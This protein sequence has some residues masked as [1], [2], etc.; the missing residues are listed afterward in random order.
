MRSFTRL[1]PRAISANRKWLVSGMTKSKSDFFRP[2]KQE[3]AHDRRTELVREMLEK[4]SA[5]RDA[6]T[7]KLRALRLAKEAAGKTAPPPAKRKKSK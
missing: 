7:A 6:K 1:M 2:S 3:S 5:T 4:E